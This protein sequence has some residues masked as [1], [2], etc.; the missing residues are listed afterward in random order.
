[1]TQ[2][3]LTDADAARAYTSTFLDELDA[4]Y[5]WTDAQHAQAEADADDAYNIA[6]DAEWFGIDAQA[7]WN[8]LYQITLSEWG[9]PGADEAAA[10]WASAAGT[11]ASVEEAEDTY[12]AYGIVVGTVEATAEDVKDVGTTAG[13]ALF[14]WRYWAAAAAAAFGIA[15]VL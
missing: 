9:M 5:G 2:E 14:D 11:V 13:A 15:W 6:D 3:E 4:R 7:Y 1:M 8:A 12:D 10:V